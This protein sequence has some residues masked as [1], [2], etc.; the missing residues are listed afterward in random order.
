MGSKSS[1]P[2][3]FFVVHGD[4]TTLHCDGFLVP[5]DDRGN[6][7]NFWQKVIGE[8]DEGDATEW[9]RPK[10][11]TSVQSTYDLPRRADGSPVITL[12]VTVGPGWSAARVVASAIAALDSLRERVATG[13]GRFKPLIAMPMVGTG[14]GMH[15]TQRQEIADEVVDRIPK[16]CHERGVDVALVLKERSAFAAVQAA[17]RRH[18]QSGGTEFAH[19]DQAL[20]AKADDLGKKAAEGELSL[21]VGAGASQPMGLPSWD[22]LLE[23]L[24][25]RADEKDPAGAGAGV[26]TDKLRR[27][28]ALKQRLGDDYHGALKEL[29]D[30]DVHAIGH[31]LLGSLGVRQSVTTNY[32][33]ALELA[34]RGQGQEPCVL[35]R[36][37]ALGGRP[38]VLKIH[39]DIEETGSVVLTQEE[40]DA[41]AEKGARC[42]AWCRR[43][44]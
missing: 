38:W 34:M 44:S 2:G 17:R 43:C 30:K 37:E 6:V 11:L 13:G 35:M 39:G 15:G 33:R 28:Q 5:C 26:Q 3:H 20:A 16:W 19:L 14:E 18:V 25:R 10:G 36:Q 9:C 24:Q 42:T 7:S 29:C 4:L 40:Y 22:G 1:S 41:L 32:D 12:V 21:F 27:A 23:A 31:A 8:V